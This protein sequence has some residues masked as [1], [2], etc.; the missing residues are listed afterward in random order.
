M[1]VPT[2]QPGRAA[3]AMLTGNGSFRARVMG[4][5]LRVMAGALGLALAAPQRPGGGAPPGP[6]ID[7]GTARGSPLDV[8][9]ALFLFSVACLING[10]CVAALAVARLV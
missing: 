8:R 1:F 2:V 3:H 7:A 6:W 4:W 5:P 9:R 10:A